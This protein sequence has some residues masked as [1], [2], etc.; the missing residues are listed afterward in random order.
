MIL[1]ISIKKNRLGVNKLKIQTIKRFAQQLF[2]KYCE[3]ELTIF[4][5]EAVDQRNV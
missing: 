2:S 1:K 5:E 3:L 4:T